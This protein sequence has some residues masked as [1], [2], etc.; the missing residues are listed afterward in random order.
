MLATISKFT[1]VGDAF[2]SRKPQVYHMADLEMPNEK[3]IFKSEYFGSSVA[4][5][6]LYLHKY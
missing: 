3:L 4:A 2:I 5:I 1:N 6:E